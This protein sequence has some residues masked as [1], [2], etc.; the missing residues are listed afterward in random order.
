MEFWCFSDNRVLHLLEAEVR[1]FSVFFRCK[2]CKDD[3][4]WNFTRVYGPTLKKERE[5]F[6]GELGAVRGLWGGR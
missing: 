5:D 4:C 2:N 6:R 1:T 3:F